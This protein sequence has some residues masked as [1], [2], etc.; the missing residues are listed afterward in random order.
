MPQF[1]ALVVIVL[2]VV[3]VSTDHR[4]CL[5]QVAVLE[6]EHRTLVERKDYLRQEVAAL[7]SELRTLAETSERIR[8]N[9]AVLSRRAFWQTVQQALLV[10][11]LVGYAGV[12][13]WLTL[14]IRN[15]KLV[16]LVIATPLAT[17]CQ[18]HIECHRRLDALEAAVP[19]LK[20]QVS[21]LS[22][23]VIALRGQVSAARAT[24]DRLRD[25]T[26]HLESRVRLLQEN[27]ETARVPYL[28]LLA[29]VTAILAWS[30]TNRGAR[31]RGR[32]KRSRGVS[33]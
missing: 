15:R 3:L 19:L 1:V 23:Q 9:N 31:F 16:I 11:F 29:L 6:A 20:E 33:L 25:E 2:I 22:K 18:G 28:L 32:S 4:D 26:E 21:S 13:L 12:V 27:A 17:G 24:L 5:D 7:S 8:A 10:L 14:R 30:A